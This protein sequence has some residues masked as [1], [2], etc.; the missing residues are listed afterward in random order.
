M[1]LILY[2]NDE[3]STVPL[4]YTVSIKVTVYCSVLGHYSV[5]YSTALR[6]EKSIK[7]TGEAPRDPTFN[8]KIS[9]T[10]RRVHEKNP[11]YD[12]KEQTIIF[13]QILRKNFF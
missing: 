13:I 6:Q 8:N 2:M 7:G 9:E 11:D 10:L 4:P 3:D 5:A 12:R 1:Y